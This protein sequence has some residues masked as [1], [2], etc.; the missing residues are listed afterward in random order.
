MKRFIKVSVVLI[1]L[2]FA[3][4]AGAPASSQGECFGR[5]VAACKP[6][7]PSCLLACLSACGIITHRPDV[8]SGQL[9]SACPAISQ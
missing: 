4:P 2:C 9:R 1:V 6:A 7:T 3:M 8:P 5:C